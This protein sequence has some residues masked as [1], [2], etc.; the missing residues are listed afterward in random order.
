MPRQCQVQL[1]QLQEKKGRRTGREVHLQRASRLT[2][3]WPGPTTIQTKA[4]CQQ[5]IRT[6]TKLLCYPQA[7]PQP[8]NKFFKSMFLTTEPGLIILA[9]HMQFVKNLKKR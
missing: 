1:Q 7:I 2:K 4:A 9:Q 8:G 3:N 5:A 6:Q